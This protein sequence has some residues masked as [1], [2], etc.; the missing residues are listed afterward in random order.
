MARDPFRNYKFEVEIDGF[1]HLGFAKVTGLSHTIEVIEYREGGE[2]ETS[3][4]L[5]GQS[6]FDPVTLERGTGAFNDFNDWAKEIFNLDAVA[7]AQGDDESFRKDITIYL[8]NKA[9]DRVKKWTVFNAWPS[10]RTVGD[11][12]ASGNDVLI[13]TLEIQNEGIKEENLA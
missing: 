10:S 11:L 7:G 5:P 1:T 12:D 13:E 4:K 8:K 6:S 2:N 9:G 3:R